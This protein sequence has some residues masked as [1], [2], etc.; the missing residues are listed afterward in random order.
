MLRFFITAG[1]FV[2]ICQSAQA[3]DVQLFKTPP[4]AEEMGRVLFSKE[5]TPDSFSEKTS[6]Q[7]KTR[8]ISFGKKPNEP[9]EKK[10]ELSSPQKSSDD[11]VGLPIEFAYNSSQISPTSTPF[12]AEI[13]KM[14][15]LPEFSTKRLIIEGHTDAKGSEDYNRYLSKMRAEAIKN[16]LADNYQIQPNR[17]IV[18]GLGESDPLPNFDPNDAVNRRVQFR[19]SN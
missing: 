3:G 11:A 17:L 6:P 16:Y 12:L 14:L 15:S 4:S 10:A 18:T 19:S 7:V 9:I 2:V 13:G 5:S 1:V 8:S